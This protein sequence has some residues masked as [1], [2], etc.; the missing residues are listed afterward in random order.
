MQLDPVSLPTTDLGHESDLYVSE[1]GPPMV[2][3]ILS[4][5]VGR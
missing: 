2:D 4:Q 3:S 5:F 1:L